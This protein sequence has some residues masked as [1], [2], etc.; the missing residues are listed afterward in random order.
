MTDQSAPTEQ[1]I[2]RL[3]DYRP[4]PYAIPK[5]ELEIDL[6]PQAA[7]IIA[8]L[9]IERRPG[10]EPGVPLKLDG[11]GIKL[12]SLRI[13]GETLGNN[14]YHAAP[15][16]LELFNPPAEPFTLEI[17]TETNPDANR[18]LMGLYRSNGVFCTQCE[19]EG[20]RRITYFYDRPDV[21]SVYTVRLSADKEACPILLSNGNKMETGDLPEG[22]HFA[23]WHDP[24][25][26]P[27][28]LFAC[29]GGALE[30][31]KDHF[32]TK[33][34]KDVE[35]NIYVEKG[36]SER[37]LYAMDSLKRAFKWDEEKFGRVYDLDLF[38]IVAVSDFNMGAMENKS[39]NIFN[40][41]YVLADPQTAS[42][43]DYA[44]VERVIAHEYFHNWTG[45]RITCRD[46]F[47]L[48]LKEGLTVFRDQE[49]SSDQRSRSVKRLEDVAFLIAHQFPEDNGPLAH[50]VRPRQYAEINNFY[51]T[52]VYEKGAEVVRMLP[53]LLGQ[54]G[55]SK[56]MDLYFTRHDGQACTIEDFIQCFADSSGYDFSRF[57]LWYDQAGTP[58]VTA[59]WHYDEDAKELSLTLEQSLRPTDASPNPQPMLIPVRFAL[60]G[61]EGKELN[62]E[63]KDGAVRDD[64]LLLTEAKQEFCLKVEEP[65]VPS[66]LRG[67]SAPIDMDV[68]LTP[69]QKLFLARHDSDPV[70]RY[71][72]L[73]GLLIDTLM[74]GAEMEEDGMPAPAADY[75]LLR[76]IVDI[77]GEEKLEPAYRAFCLRLP[78]ETEIAAAIGKNI[79]PD[80]IFAAR[81]SFQE[82]MARAGKNTFSAVRQIHEITE[83][84]SPNAADAGK[85]ALCHMLLEYESIAAGSPEMAA[86]LYERADNMTERLS[87]LSIM[88]RHFYESAEAQTALADFASRFENDALI[89]DKWFALQ[90]S[91]PGAD[92][93]DRTRELTRHKQFSFDNPNRV[94]ALIGT[95]FA[96]C[97]TGFH[98]ADGAA[99]RWMSAIILDIDKDNPQLAARLLTS[100]R[101]WRQLEPK[102]RSLLRVEL[103]RI[104][105]AD[106]L[107]PDSRDII[108]RL[109]AD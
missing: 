59:D 95:F 67:F 68:T 55:F 15:D 92:T 107:S 104:A 89:M 20:F 51:T 43:A 16:G 35:L 66:L 31:V 93:L 101:S 99:Y 12:Q 22:R 63:V 103:R 29:V 7:Q 50:P 71:R 102:R 83:E 38:N 6:R 11:D 25:P 57:M 80:A 41:K 91:V 40:D 87:G 96:Q 85:R 90:A 33:D 34:G 5:T 73:S 10:T 47:Q 109:L 79:N 13:N 62:F 94:R 70:N 84:F 2:F 52:T 23:V 56:G 81:Q 44:N 42:D 86:K 77:A 37:A 54:E 4:T 69:E 60:L 8:K 49:F 21:L 9:A 1:H 105:A 14:A 53:A 18:A 98:R 100:Q 19:A 36:K 46:W 76:L 75:H 30:E 64:L 32:Q 97:P 88:A 78:S 17:V 26:K 65:P 72:S 28:Y 24:F 39:L 74:D 27:S 108:T 58:K 48:C 82:D 61:R 106:N 3:E 45:D